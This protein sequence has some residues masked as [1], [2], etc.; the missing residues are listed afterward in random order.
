MTAFKN[1][2]K[3]LKLFALAMFLFNLNNAAFAETGRICGILDVDVYTS[4]RCIGPNCM[5]VIRLTNSE[6]Y[7]Q[8]LVANVMALKPFLKRNVCIANAN[9]EVNNGAEVIRTSADKISILQ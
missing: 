9:V 5:P 8:V 7:A 3:I 4:P 6:V 2:T 1:T